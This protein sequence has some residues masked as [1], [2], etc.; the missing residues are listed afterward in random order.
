MEIQVLDPARVDEV[1]AMLREAHTHDLPDDPAYV[2]GFEKLRILNPF[3]DEPGTHWIVVSGGRVVAHAEL[4]LPHLDNRTNAYVDLTVR[5]DARRRGVGRLLWDHVADLARAADRKLVF[6]EAKM[7][8]AGEDFARAIGGELG[9]YSARRRLV[10]DDATRAT[11]SELEASSRAAGAGYEI[12]TFVGATPEEWLDGMAYLTGR[13]STD[14]PLENLELQPEAYDA[15]RLRAREEIG[16]VRG[17]VMY[18]ALAVESATGVVVAMTN[19]GMTRED[20]THAWQWNTIVDPDHRGHRLG[21]WVKVANLVL[22]LDHEPDLQTVI[23]WNAA[24]NEHMIAVNEAIGFRL[25]DHWGE[26]QARL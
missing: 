6:F 11:A 17:A 4:T 15:P 1:V 26:W 19:V 20:P 12:V 25:L 23:T 7:D 5:P 18:Q 22:M 16:L 13:M 24:S 14:A 3:P 10:V 8:S 21:T 9:I 2:P